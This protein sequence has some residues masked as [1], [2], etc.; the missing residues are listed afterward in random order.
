MKLDS[1]RIEIAQLGKYNGAEDRIFKVICT[2]NRLFRT[3]K[4]FKRKDKRRKYLDKA[5]V[6]NIEMYICKVL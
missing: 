3:N 5:D 4:Y 2:E 6:S 1:K